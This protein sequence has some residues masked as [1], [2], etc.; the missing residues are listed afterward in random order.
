MATVW[1]EV[2]TVMLAGLAGYIAV[3]GAYFY[4]LG[5]LRLNKVLKIVASSLVSVLLF[6]SAFVDLGFIVLVLGQR[7]YYRRVNK[8]HALLRR[9]TLIVVIILFD[10]IGD[11]TTFTFFL[12]GKIANLSQLEIAIIGVPAQSLAFLVVIWQLKK[13]QLL[14]TL[15]VHTDTALVAEQARQMKAFQLYLQEINDY[16]QEI[17]NFRHDYKNLLLTLGNRIAKSGDAD[18]QAYYQQMV[19]YSD[20]QVRG[21][22]KP[23][24]LA[25]LEQ[26]ELQSLRSVILAKLTKANQLGIETQLNVTGWVQGGRVNELELARIV[27]ILLDNAIEASSKQEQKWLGIGLDSY[28]EDGVDILIENK[29]AGDKA[30]NLTAWFE[31]GYTTKGSNHGRGLTIVNQLCDKNLID[32]EVEYKRGL[33]CFILGIGV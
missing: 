4:L 1:I 18:L 29:F 17:A 16:Y 31:R 33:I 10:A 21:V 11:V 13:K 30:P 2:G 26:I 5:E 22:I 14:K 6:L 24:N 28:G 7:W 12:I 8:A 23:R 9:L 27:A 19:T 3:F 25:Q 32:L 20:Q 15:A